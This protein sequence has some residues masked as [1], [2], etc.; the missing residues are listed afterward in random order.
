MIAALNNN[1]EIIAQ[2][3]SKGANINA[4]NDKGSTSLHQ[5]IESTQHAAVFALLERLEI[6]VDARM[7]D[8][9]TPLHCAANIGVE[10][11]VESLLSQGAD[12][13]AVQNESFTP[14]H[15]AARRGHEEAVRVLLVN[16]ANSDAACSCHS[17]TPLHLAAQAGE[18]AIIWLL[19]ENGANIEATSVSS[20]TPLLAAAKSANDIGLI[21]VL[22]SHGADASAANSEG[23]TALHYAVENNDAHLLQFLLEHFIQHSLH[24]LDFP[25]QYGKTPLHS[26]AEYGYS[27]LVALLADHGADTEAKNDRG[28]TPLWM[29]AESGHA[30][31]VEV[32]VLR[33]A[34]IDAPNKDSGFTTVFQA[35]YYGHADVIKALMNFGANMTARAN[36]GFMPIYNAVMTNQKETLKLFLDHGLY[37]EDM[38][39]ECLRCACTD[40]HD[41]AARLL[42]QA[43]ANT[44]G[45]ET[46]VQLLVGDMQ[47]GERDL[48]FKDTRSI[49]KVRSPTT[50]IFCLTYSPY[51]AMWN[52]WTRKQFH[53]AGLPAMRP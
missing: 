41:D 1:V 14:L 38:L 29:A 11:F 8:G 35:A 52:L 34:D 51:L 13:Q 31:I 15:L 12:I 45:F 28:G 16:G 40:G 47:D 25:D 3:L 33:G 21:R 42:V 46:T 48:F 26:A 39:Q 7:R 27:A 4:K 22:L 10:I 53:K 50:L 36:T 17:I 44:N 20:I 18:Q 6:E 32:L 2:L 23:F 43:G 19:L 49:K 9:W 24:G 5:A 37:D 30:D